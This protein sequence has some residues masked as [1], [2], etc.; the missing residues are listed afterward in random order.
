MK[1]AEIKITFEHGIEKT[2]YAKLQ[3]EKPEGNS[4]TLYEMFVPSDRLWFNDYE[5]IKNPKYTLILGCKK[6][7][8]VELIEVREFDDEEKINR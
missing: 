1:I 5:D 3:S 2:V 7:L 4:E 6:I 8:Y